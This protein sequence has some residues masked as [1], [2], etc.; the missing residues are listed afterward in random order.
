[1]L[2]P[3]ANS[4]VINGKDAKFAKM[5]Y[6]LNP[7]IEIKGIKGVVTAT[8]GCVLEVGK[9]EI[10]GPIAEGAPR[11]VVPPKALMDNGGNFFMTETACVLC[12]DGEYT[13][14]VPDGDLFCMPCTDGHS[15]W[16]YMRGE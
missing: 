6:T 15:T 11:S 16:R 10:Q 5:R 14:F 1:M 2:D 9:L 3:G 8:E 12:K 13:H 7:P 4:C